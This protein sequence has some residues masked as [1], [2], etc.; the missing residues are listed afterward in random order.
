MEQIFR[1]DKKRKTLGGICAGL[2]RWTG[3][4]PILWKLIFIF[5]AIWPG[6]PALLIYILMW[7]IVPEE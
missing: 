7:I 3:T 2:S 5:G 6:C 1:R 4:D